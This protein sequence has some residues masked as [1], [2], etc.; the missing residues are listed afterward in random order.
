MEDERR[1][2]HAVLYNAVKI[3]KKNHLQPIHS[4]RCCNARGAHSHTAVRTLRTI[5]LPY[6]MF[7]SLIK[8]KLN[9]SNICTLHDSV[10]PQSVLMQT[11]THFNPFMPTVKKR[12]HLSQGQ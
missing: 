6:F 8:I 9:R 10:L 11:T 2:E 4:L 7:P 5:S 12:A 3:G 1:F